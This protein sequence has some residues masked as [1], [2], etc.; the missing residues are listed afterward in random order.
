MY[1]AQLIEQTYGLYFVHGDAK[2]LVLWNL[3]ETLGMLMLAVPRKT[4]GRRAREVL[5]SGQPE[6]LSCAEH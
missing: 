3:E 5:Q 6:S 4:R 1:E 2:P